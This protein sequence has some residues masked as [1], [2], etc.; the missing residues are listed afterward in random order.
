MTEAVTLELN[1]RAP[2]YAWLA[3]L[4]VRE[5]Q[6]PDW[7]ALRAE[8]IRGIL[9]RLEPAL[10]AELD[11]ELTSLAQENLHAEFARL[12]LLPG[13]VSPFATQWISDHSMRDRTRDEITGLIKRSLSALGRMEIH[14][15]PWGRLPSDH[16]A[17]IFDVVAQADASSDPRDRK[18]AAHLDRELLGAWL[19]SFGRTL[20]EQAH[21]PLFRALG[22]VL[23]G[24]HPP[25]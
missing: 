19:G 7:D 1:Q 12:F 25:D 5:I 9:A 2:I 22:E 15:E 6:A 3:R 24:L 23:V 18:V 16:I 21:H 14:Q 8:P 11:N 20:S 4:L 10:D 13:G 17:V